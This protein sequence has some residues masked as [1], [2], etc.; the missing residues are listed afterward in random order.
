M[1]LP[2][3]TYLQRSNVSQ[4]NKLAPLT[5]FLA[6]PLQ[7]IIRQRHVPAASHD[8]HT[9]LIAESMRRPCPVCLQRTPDIVIGQAVSPAAASTV[10][11]NQPLFTFS[12]T[13]SAAAGS[14]RL[15]NARLDVSLSA[16]LARTGDILALPDGGLLLGCA[17][18]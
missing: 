12:S 2:M 1:P 15:N 4:L 11:G 6:E 9:L 17:C 16:G 13:V 5:F 7:P 3:C 10:P 18:C 8:T 14:G